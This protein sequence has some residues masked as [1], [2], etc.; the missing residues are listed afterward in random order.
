MPRGVDRVGAKKAAGC[1]ALVSIPARVA[2][3]WIEGGRPGRPERKECMVRYLCLIQE[4]A[5]PNVEYPPEEREKT[6]RAY[7]DFTQE[8]TQRGIMQGGEALQPPVTATTV[9]VKN[10][11]VLTTDGPYA[12][13]K[14]WLA[15]F[16]LIDCK[17]LDEAIEVA[18]KIP[19]AAHGA[20]EVRPI[21]ELPPEYTQS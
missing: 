10:D 15:G 14:E 3:L 9:R 11:E 18:S 1:R 5:D 17:D 21:M 2:R 7:M 19:A 6:M 12:E 8:I 20:I 16:Y 13:T 4:A